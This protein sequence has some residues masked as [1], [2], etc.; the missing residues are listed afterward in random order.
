[1]ATTVVAMGVTSPGG[2]ECVF[3]LMTLSRYER[4]ILACDVSIWSSKSRASAMPGELI[5]KSFVTR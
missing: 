4:A 2:I 1:M 3:S 5:P